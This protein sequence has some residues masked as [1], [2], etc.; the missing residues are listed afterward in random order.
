VFGSSNPYARPGETQV[1]VSTR[2][3]KSTDHYNGTAEQLQRQTLDTYVLNM[4][5]A[6]DF[7][8]THVFTERVS[9]SVGLPFVAASWGIPS[10][11]SAGAGARA[12]E[13]AHGL[14]DIAVGARAWV[15]NT[16]L[17]RSGNIAVG[18]GIKTPS[19]NSGY[20]DMYPDSA[21]RNNALRFVD[22]SVQPGDGG[23]GLLVD[24]SGFRRIP[25]GQLFGSLS[26]LANPRDRNDTTSGSI[27]RST[28]PNP[29]T[30][31]DT[32]FNSVPDQFLAR[33]GAAMPIGR[34]GFAGSLAWRAEGVPRYDLIGASHGFRRPG[35]ELFIEPGVSFAK[36]R[37]FYS[38]QVPIGYYRNRFPNPYT[39]NAGDATFPKYIVLASYG[40]RFGKKSMAVSDSAICP[41]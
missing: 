3:L 1:T 20:K 21:G 25:H 7:N 30:A 5:H 16:Q 26:Y 23:W 6:V 11:T 14:G 28:T 34:T 2:N 33:F 13:D 4:Q 19:G 9:M 40:Y 10:P 24:I 39:G 35:I 8:I 31:A 38:L 29:S 27:N 17:H 22:Q 12:N 36:G 41:Q 15:L 32:A 37:Q 18:L